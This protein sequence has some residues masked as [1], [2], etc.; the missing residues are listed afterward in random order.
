M[1]RQVLHFI[2][3]PCQEMNERFC[4]ATIHHIL[5]DEIE[6]FTMHPLPPTTQGTCHHLYEVNISAIKVISNYHFILFY[7]RI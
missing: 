1:I 3:T 2:P 7:V 6:I 5:Q 4:L